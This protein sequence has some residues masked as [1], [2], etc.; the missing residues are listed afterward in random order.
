MSVL[1]QQV[2]LPI[3]AAE[4]TDSSTRSFAGVWTS[5]VG[6]P[7]AV[8]LDQLGVGWARVTIVWSAIQPD[9]ADRFDWPPLDEAMSSASGRGRRSVLA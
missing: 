4:S 6:A 7:E 1:L 2:A 8:T 9:S 5:S 3:A